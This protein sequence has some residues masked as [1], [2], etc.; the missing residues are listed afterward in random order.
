MNSM[1]YSVVYG[2]IGNIESFQQ[3]SKIRKSK[4]STTF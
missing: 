2:R 1:D 3:I 4:P